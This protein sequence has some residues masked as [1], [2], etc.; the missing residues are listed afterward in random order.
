MMLI[1]V[2]IFLLYRLDAAYVR[3]FVRCVAK[4]NDLCV[5]MPAFAYVRVRLGVVRDGEREYE[6]SLE[7][8]RLMIG[9]GKQSKYIRF[10]W[11]RR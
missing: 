1:N 4:V 2:I 8:Y 10:E 5:R 6:N 7:E 11:S 3:V 9:K